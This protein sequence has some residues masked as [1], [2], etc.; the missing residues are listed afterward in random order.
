MSDKTNASRRDFLKGSTAVVAG[1]RWSAA[2][3]GPFRPRG[4]Q[5]RDQGGVDRLRRTRQRRDP[6]LPGRRP[7]DQVVAVADAFEDKAKGRPAACSRTIVTR[8]RRHPRRPGVLEPDGYL[9]RL[10]RGRT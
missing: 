8:S 1:W 6:Q 10:K 7:G 2:E 9:K 3:L 5:R 4:R